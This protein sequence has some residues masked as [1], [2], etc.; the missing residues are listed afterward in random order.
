M[1]KCPQCGLEV[2]NLVP[3]QLD[4]RTRIKK[5]D[6]DFPLIDEVCRSCMTEMRK[7]AFSAGGVLLSQ[8]RAKDDRKKKLWQARVSLVKK[9]HAF[10][11][12]NLYSE[13]AVSYEKYLKLLE[14]VFD[15]QPGNLTPEILKEA[16]RTAELTV[17]AGVY[18]DLIRIYDT[19]DKYG[20][21]QKMAARQLSRF[22]SYT[23]I[24][25][26]LIKKGQIFLKQARHPEIIKAFLAGAKKKKG[27]C[28]I[29]T[30]AFEDP[31]AVEVLSLRVF[32]D[33]R[34]KAS[35]FGRKF[36]YFY[37]K[38]SPPIAC[39]VDKHAWLKPSV[40]AILRFVIKCVS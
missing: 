28:F 38:T 19:S 22:I 16:A 37:Y 1:I 3:L 17:I 27:G 13:A 25:P 5:M 26:D 40:R 20:D 2:S 11:A 12:G 36:I 33:H 31:Y 30:S 8:Q 24:Y 4:V 21:R 7:K 29:A 32:R 18:W 23:P 14:V 15:A 6:P 10:M 35:P 34:L 9:G 39:F